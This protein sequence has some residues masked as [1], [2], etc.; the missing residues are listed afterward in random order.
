MHLLL[1]GDE[2]AEWIKKLDEAAIFAG[3][4]G[5]EMKMR[6]SQKELSEN[7]ALIRELIAKCEEVSRR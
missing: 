2:R 5:N 4:R 3:P 6:I 7:E 1:N